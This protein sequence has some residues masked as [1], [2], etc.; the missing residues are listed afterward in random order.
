MTSSPTNRWEDNYLAAVLHWTPSHPK[1]DAAIPYRA[2]VFDD[3]G[4]ALE[5]AL[6]YRE[7]KAFQGVLVWPVDEFGKLKDFINN[8]REIELP[9]FDSETKE[10][11]TLRLV[12]RPGK[13]KG[14]RPKKTDGG[15]A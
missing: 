13:L 4:K 10:P 8:T 3:F 14:T 11:T 7:R 2:D 9:M 5:W 15:D 12:L 1:G 6:S